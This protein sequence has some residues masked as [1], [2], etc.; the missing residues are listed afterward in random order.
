MERVD[1]NALSPSDLPRAPGTAL[2]TR[3]AAPGKHWRIAQ[4]LIDTEEHND[5]EA[6]F[7]V[8]LA[9]SRTEN[10]AVVSFRGVQPIGSTADLP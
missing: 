8:D 4:V 5:W 9:A 3:D 7:T 10:R 6:T 1:P 2:P